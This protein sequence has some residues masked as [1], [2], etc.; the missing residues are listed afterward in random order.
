[1]KE[2]FIRINKYSHLVTQCS[3]LTN[4][5]PGRSRAL[6]DEPLVLR[7]V[8][9]YKDGSTIYLDLPAANY[10]ATSI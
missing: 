8:A 6:S 3:A 2:P 1:M 4:K 7:V 10:L 9:I 5:T